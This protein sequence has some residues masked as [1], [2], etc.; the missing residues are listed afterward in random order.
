MKHYCEYWGGDMCEYY[1]EGYCWAEERPVK[2][3]QELCLV[4][5]IDSE[6]LDTKGEIL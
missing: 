6:L 4:D 5:E 1:D 2:D 3:V